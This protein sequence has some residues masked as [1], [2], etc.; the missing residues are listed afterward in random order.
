M[1]KKNVLVVNVAL[2]KLSKQNSLET[3]MKF[4]FSQILDL[5]K[6]SQEKEHEFIVQGLPGLKD[7]KA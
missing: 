7:G 2:K 1:I 4:F 6:F 3:M 5:S